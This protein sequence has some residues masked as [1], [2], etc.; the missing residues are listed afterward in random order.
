MIQPKEEHGKAINWLGRYLKA[1]ATKGLIF[2]PGKTSFQVYVDA[3]FAGNWDKST[4]GDDN[5]TA[6]SRYGYIVTYAGCPIV[7]ASKIQQEIALSS[8]EAE[9]SLGQWSDRNRNG[10][11]DASKDKT[12]QHQVPPFSEPCR[13]RRDH[14]TSDQD[15]PPTCGHTYEA[16]QPNY[17]LTTSQDDH[18]MVKPSTL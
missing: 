7:W 13:Q 6:R 10:T 2:N 3:D 18:G 11:E 15:G 4:A 14:H 5:S 17:S 8:T 1:T 12:Y 9:G 16:H